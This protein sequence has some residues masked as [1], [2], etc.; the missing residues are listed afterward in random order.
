M[1]VSL[2][3]FISTANLVHGFSLLAPEDSVT[4]ADVDY[5]DADG[6]CFYRRVRPVQF[7]CFVLASGYFV[8]NSGSTSLL[9]IAVEQ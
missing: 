6:G 9:A 1:Y 2:F 8:S 4:G 3:A 5:T 7:S